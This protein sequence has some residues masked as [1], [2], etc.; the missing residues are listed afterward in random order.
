MGVQVVTGSRYLGGFIG[1]RETE[2]QWIQ[3]K[4]EGWAESVYTL[5]R[6]ARKHLQ[7]AYAGTAEVNPTGV[8]ICAAGHPGQCIDGLRPPLHLR[9]DP[10]ILRLLLPDES[11]NLS[12]PCHDLYAHPAE[13][14]LGPGYIRLGHH[15][16][17]LGGLRKVPRGRTPQLE[18]PEVGHNVPKFPSCPLCR[19]HTT[20][21]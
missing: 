21:A 20:A 12:A 13:V 9:L 15:Q 5:A 11:S 2:D 7:S 8:G 18:V 14:L 4:V 10:L 19:P 6:V 1:E 3:S 16:D 17:A